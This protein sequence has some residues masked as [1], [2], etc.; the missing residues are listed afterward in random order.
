MGR[1]KKKD[2]HSSTTHYHFKHTVE[3][4][5]FH[6]PIGCSTRGKKFKIPLFALLPNVLEITTIF[7]L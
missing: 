7:P 2:E 3:V 4:S 6:F 1:T 5:C